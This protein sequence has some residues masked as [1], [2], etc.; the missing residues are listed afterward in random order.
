LF[1][2]AN[3][4]VHGH[5]FIAE[6]HVEGRALA[7]RRHQRW[8]VATVEP[9]GFG[10][11]GEDKNEAFER[12][13]ARLSAT[14]FEIARGA[15]TYAEFE[16]RVWERLCRCDCDRHRRWMAAVDAVGGLGPRHGSHVC[17]GSGRFDPSVSVSVERIDDPARRFAPDDNRVDAMIVLDRRSTRRS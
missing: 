15:A 13:R 7:E 10:E 11:L 8:L 9:D 3:L 12:L 16:Q 5:A 4:I 1:R 6:V 14:L 17:D 2:F